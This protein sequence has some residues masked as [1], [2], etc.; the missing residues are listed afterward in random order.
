MDEREILR[1]L[2]GLGIDTQDD[3][4]AA[5]ERFYDLQRLMREWV[6]SLIRG[7]HLQFTPQSLHEN[8][9]RLH[10]EDYIDDWLDEASEEWM[11]G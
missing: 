9:A 4:D 7:G 10:A 1:I 5:R 2:G 11:V 6:K 3:S 8:L